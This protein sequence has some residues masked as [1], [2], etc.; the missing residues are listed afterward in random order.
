MR[1]S[2]FK[3][4]LW[5]SRHCKH[6]RLKR[7]ILATFLSLTFVGISLLPAH[8]F[9]QTTG[10]TC[11]L[12]KKGI[13]AQGETYDASCRMELNQ[14]CDTAVRTNQEPLPPTCNQSA[15]TLAACNAQRGVQFEQPVVCVSK[16]LCRDVVSKQGQ[17]ALLTSDT[18]CRITQDCFWVITGNNKCAIS[19]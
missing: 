13:S 6:M 10:Q 9:A 12:L 4:R 19:A 14:P 17:C 11:C 3:L 8:L 2:S 15:E 18:T 16:S 5:C 1:I 7:Q